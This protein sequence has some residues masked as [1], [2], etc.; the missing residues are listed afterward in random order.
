MQNKVVTF[1]EKRVR[2][3]YCKWALSKKKK[4]LGELTL[5][6]KKLTMVLKRVCLL[7][8]SEFHY[9][10]TE[11]VGRIVTNAE[12]NVTIQIKGNEIR[13]I[14][15]DMITVFFAM[16]EVSMYLNS[17]FDRATELRAKKREDEIINIQMDHL[18]QVELTLIES[19]KKTSKPI[20][21]RQKTRPAKPRETILQERDILKIAIGD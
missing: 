7:P 4:S 18:R 2:R 9:G 16:P 17:I 1:I 21:L 3:A 11:H 8:D 20:T 6:E 5:F 13:F 14:D 10:F 19:P 12:A 15:S